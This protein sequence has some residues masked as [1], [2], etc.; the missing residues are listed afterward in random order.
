MAD[1]ETQPFEKTIGTL[2]PVARVVGKMLETPDN[3]GPVPVELGGV[4][5]QVTMKTWRPKYGPQ[6][7]WVFVSDEPVAVITEG[8]C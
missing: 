8:S 4:S 6:R 3:D 5:A 7:R 1:L 2:G